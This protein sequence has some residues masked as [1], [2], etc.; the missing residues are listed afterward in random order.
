MLR[1]ALRGN[2]PR[3]ALVTATATAVAGGGYYYYY[4]YRPFRDDAPPLHSA[5]RLHVSLACPLVSRETVAPDVARLRFALPSA[6]HASGLTVASHVLAVDEGSSTT[7]AYTP[8]SPPHVKGS[9]DLLVRRYPGGEFSTALHALRVG[10]TINFRGPVVTLDFASKP[11]VVRHLCLVAGGTGI[12][13]LYQILTH[14]LA[15]PGDVTEVRLLYA[16]RT[17]EDVLLRRELD[18]LAAR[19]PDRLR[20][21]YVVEEQEGP[22]VVGQRSWSSFLSPTSPA[23]QDKKDATGRIN[24]TV[25][26]E[27]LVAPTERNAAVLV[28]GPE[29]M[30]RSLCGDERNSSHDGG[31]LGSLGYGRRVWQ[32]TDQG[33][34]RSD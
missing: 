9:F 25:L 29:G 10:D 1:H 13:P 3:T 6:E 7:R 21:R 2:G 5:L 31:L 8:V 19:H 20:V 14:V 32:F 23:P 15:T 11:N 17:S 33:V 18:A 4:Y 16:N 27:F 34:R 26:R 24:A 12:A 22:P 28:C 30:L